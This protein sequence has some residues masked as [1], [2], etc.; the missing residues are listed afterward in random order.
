MH[1]NYYMSPLFA[2][3]ILSVAGSV[4]AAKPMVLQDTDFQSVQKNFRLSLPFMTKDHLLSPA[5][6]LN[7]LEFIKKN[8]DK[9]QVTH[10]RMQQMYAGVQVYNG[11]AILHTKNPESL[12]TDSSVFMNGTLYEGLKEELGVPAK[13]LINRGQ[14]AVEAFKKRHTGGVMEKPEV[15]PVIYIDDQDKAHWAYKIVARINHDVGRP[16]LINAIV[17]ANTFEPFQTWDEIQTIKEAVKGHGFGGNP[18]IGHLEYGK[19][20]LPLLDMTLDTDT[21]TCY[22]ENSAVKVVDMEHA[23]DWFDPVKKRNPMQFTCHAITDNGQTSYTTGYRADGY[24]KIN[25]AYNPANDAMYTGTVIKA[26]YKDWYDM[27]ALVQPDGKPLQLVMRVHFDS[28]YENAFWDPEQKYMTFGDGQFYFYPLVSLGIAAHEVSHGFTS[29]HANLRYAEQSGGLNESFSDMAAQAAEFY[30]TGKSSWLIGAEIV[31]PGSGMK[32]LRYMDKPSKDGRSI[33]TA[34]QYYK[35]LN[36]H[37]SSGVFNRLFYL[38]ANTAGWNT[39]LAFDVMVKANVDYWTPLA[40]F[41]EAGCG[42][43][44]ATKDLNYSLDAVKVALDKVRVDH[45]RCKRMDNVG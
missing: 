44:Y 26:L 37:Y 20:A 10:I 22:L 12:Q 35:G 23:M 24:D 2:A 4:E 7:N 25:G 40:T 36:V 30:S 1:P 15:T 13:D 42:V 16:Q 28:N 38:L 45:S 9:N 41:K 6:S 43:L 8:V 34:D 33:D 21:N 14:L 32:T 5:E 29:Q 11:Y 18:V 27:E 3:I 17:D 39:R 31:K 19:G